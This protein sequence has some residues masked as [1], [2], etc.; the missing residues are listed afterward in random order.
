M[1]VNYITN[2]SLEND[3]VIITITTISNND[4]ISTSITVCNIQAQDFLFPFESL[5]KPK[6]DVIQQ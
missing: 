6:Q 3:Y 2:N 1:L 5:Q 4:K